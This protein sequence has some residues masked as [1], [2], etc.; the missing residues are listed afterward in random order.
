MR[1]F[2]TYH[3]G[4]RCVGW[5][6]EPFVLALRLK[7]PVF[8]MLMLSVNDVPCEANGTS[9]TTGPI[10]VAEYDPIVLLIDGR[11]R[12][13]AAR[14]AGHTMIWAAVFTAEFAEACRIPDKAA[15]L[16]VR[17]APEI[18]KIEISNGPH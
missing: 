6:V 18:S 2:C 12:V 11:N 13:A 7:L 1:Q 9:Q 17:E 14:A 8:R 15:L 4:D 16:I 3:D 10:I 5:V